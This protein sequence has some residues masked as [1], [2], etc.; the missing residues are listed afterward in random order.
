MNNLTLGFNGE[1]QDPASGMT[2]LGNGYRTYNAV[3]MRFHCPDSI[4]P[5]G[6]GGI[7]PYAYCNDDPVN[8]ADPSGHISGS[9]I[10]GIVAGILGLSMALFTGGSSIAAAVAATSAET[11]AIAAAGISWTSVAV[12]AT[13]VASDATAI[14]SGAT[15]LSHPRTSGLLGW[16]SLAAGLVGAGAGIFG[17]TGKLKGSSTRPFG[18]LMMQ[19]SEHSSAEAGSMTIGSSQVRAPGIGLSMQGLIIMNRYE[20]EARQAASDTLDLPHGWVDG[21]FN[22]GIHRRI[23]QRRPMIPLYSGRM[24]DLAP[25]PRQLE[26]E[27]TDIYATI[28]LTPEERAYS[29]SSTLYREPFPLPQGASPSWHH[30]SPPPA[31]PYEAMDA[32]PTYKQSG[33]DELLDYHYTTH[34]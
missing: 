12:W 30:L 14:A 1:R 20:I 5:F 9:A 15:E 32:P 34:L 16:M 26:R 25:L 23:L 31:Y 33:E 29:T 7:N 28:G 22:F 13:G 4:S 8:R 2:H 6:R 18:G 21:L 19:G 24:Q 27:L 10:F 17:L 3:L 11:T